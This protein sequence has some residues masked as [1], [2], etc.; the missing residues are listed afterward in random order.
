MYT[1]Y[2][3]YFKVAN[4]NGENAELKTLSDGLQKDIRL[5]AEEKEEIMKKLKDF[6]E[7]HTTQ[8]AS[9]QQ[10]NREV[11]FIHYWYSGTLA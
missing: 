6:E 8:L 5:T 7:I 4:L 1:N 11:C 3:L 10:A 9:T 2:H